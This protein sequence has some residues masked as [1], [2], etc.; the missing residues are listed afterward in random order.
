MRK[1]SQLSNICKSD[2]NQTKQ[3]NT[4][5][6]QEWVHFADMYLLPEGAPKSHP[7]GYNF[8]ISLSISPYFYI[9]QYA[10]TT[11]DVFEQVSDLFRKYFKLQVNK[12]YKIG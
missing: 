7:A 9:F 10:E 6:K 11:P 5:K 1:A 4:H 8:Q 12:T 3:K 2:N